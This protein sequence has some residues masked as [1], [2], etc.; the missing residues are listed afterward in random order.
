LRVWISA[1]V[2]VGLVI[3]GLAMVPRMI[4]WNA[5]RSDIEA[6]AA[7]LSGHDVTIRGPIEFAILPQLVLTARDVAM[8][9]DDDHDQA[10]GFSLTANQASVR[11]AIGPFLAGRPVISDLQLRRPVLTVDQQSRAA[12]AAWPPRWQDFAAPF[13]NLDIEQIKLTDGRIELTDSS[14]ANDPA[15]RRL[16]LH[17]LSL[18]L[19][20]DEPDG[21][22]EAAGFFRTERQRFTLSATFGQP[23]RQGA[24]ASKLLITAQNG[25]E[26]TT[27]LRFSGV[28]VPFDQNPSLR[29]RLTVNGPDLQHG[30][31]AL[32]SIASYPST[33]YSIAQAQPFAIEGQIEADRIGIRAADLQLRIAERIGRG[34]IDLT[35]HPSTQLDLKAELPVLH[36]ADDADFTDFL[37]LDLLSKLQV[38]PGDIDIRLREL[39]YRDG[40]ARQ[41]SMRL[42]TGQDGATVVEQAKIQLPGLI[43]LR[44]E[45]SVHP[46]AIGP[47]L[48][49]TLAAVGDDMK[50]SLTWLGLVE[51]RDQASGWRSFSLEGEVDITSV[52]MALNAVDMRLDT[53][54]VQGDVSLRFSERRSLR[55]DIEV[56][57]PNLD[58]YG[59]SGRAPDDVE[60]AVDRLAE[61]FKAMDARVD[62]HFKRLI[63]QGVHIQEGMIK[64]ESNDGLL[65][66]DDVLVKTVGDTALTLNGLI[67]LN[68]READLNAELE[69]QRP[70]RALRHFKLDLPLAGRADRPLAVMGQAKG[71]FERFD[72]SLKTDYDDGTATMAG[73]AG[74]VDEQPW[75][76]VTISARHPDYLTLA[77]HF[78]LAPLFTAGDA[79]GPLELAGRIH[80]PEAEPWT[81]SG[82]IKLGPTTFTGSLSF[83]ETIFNGPFDA[84]LSVGTPQKDSLAPFLILAG[85]RLTGDW[86]PGRWLGRLPTTGL[87]TA[88]LDQAEGT[89]SLASKGGLV[90]DGLKMNATLSQGVLSIEEL[91]ASP[92]QGKLQGELMLERRGDQPFLAIALDLDQ[93]E[94]A[95]FAAWLGAKSG[96]EGRL[97]LLIEASSAGLTPY[98][99]MAGLAGKIDVK[100]GPGELTGLGIPN[101]K[102]A[103]ATHRSDQWSAGRALTLPFREMVA[104]AGLSRGIATI[105]KGQLTLSAAD[106][107]TREARIDGTVDLLLWII[108]LT[109]TDLATAG[110]DASGVYQLV[111]SPEDPEGFIPAGN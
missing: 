86:T 57:R 38:P 104:S 90:G 46:A 98:D 27:S 12:S 20:I 81:L 59:L 65:T 55:L 15:D 60:K 102:M 54:R 72:L 3:L 4:D 52:E 97:D 87:R 109:L 67:D 89:I 63:W 45:G 108:D 76:D 80:H 33:F 84:K 77:S 75:Y 107:D 34:R 71:T 31:A 21:T 13:L 29:G 62:A 41:A 47:H 78:G 111:G 73:Q 16:G 56:D 85:L 110:A 88:W 36:I 91:E 39:A 42:K 1:A 96:I 94:A 23:D 43:D 7:N 11:F 48:R 10:T 61:G 79:H 8:S 50:S 17:D 95:D 30:L 106:D 101:L 22:V 19:Q 66:I 35:L 44:F 25:D 100:V 83:Q 69:S 82:N 18:Q 68:D 64:A 26:Q 2:L 53:S 49:G 40:K 99:M 6:A 24:S 103:L 5:Y 58:L 32:S 28:V 92:W 105:E 74:L 14:L 51:A 9:H 93:I 37:P 70:T